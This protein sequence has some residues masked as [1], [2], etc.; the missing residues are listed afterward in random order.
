M[1]N[2]CPYKER[3]RKIKGQVSRTEA[4]SAA[5]AHIAASRLLGAQPPPIAV[6]LYEELPA[7]ADYQGDYLR[8]VK[9]RWSDEQRE[10]YNVLRQKVIRER[11][12][13]E[14]NL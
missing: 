8:E 4:I 2:F 9:S 10:Q 6:A 11:L 7:S 14:F 1:E 12:R 5:K 3:K 13:Q